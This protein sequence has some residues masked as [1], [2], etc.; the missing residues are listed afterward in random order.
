M[1]NKILVRLIVNSSPLLL[2]GL[3]PLELN[4]GL[5]APRY[6]KYGSINPYLIGIAVGCSLLLWADWAVRYEQMFRQK[7]TY[8]LLG[9]VLIFSILIRFCFFP[10]QS[11][12][13]CNALSA[14]YDFIQNNGGFLSLSKG[15]FS[16]YNV[17]YLYLLA[18]LT[19]T[20]LPSLYAIKLLSV[21]FDYGGAYGVY[22]IARLVFPDTSRRPFVAGVAVLFCPTVIFNSALWA[23]CDMMY[24]FFLLWATYFFM[25]NTP[26]QGV[27]MM[28]WFSCAFLFKLQAI[29]FVL[30]MLYAYILG[31]IRKRHIGILVG[32][33]F[34]TALPS[35]LLGR[36]FVDM[37]LVY[38]R[39]A[40]RQH[41]LSLN[42]ANI[43]QLFP[44]APVEPFKYAGI[45]AVGLAVLV[46]VF[47]F[48]KY[49]PALNA[50]QRLELALLSLGWI[51]YGL[52]QIHERYFFGVDVLA[53]LY[54]VIFPNRWHLSV[55]LIFVSL[56]SYQPYLFH[57]EPIPLWA[58]AL[59]YGYALIE[60]SR[61]W[62]D[63]VQ[64]SNRIA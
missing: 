49:R 14:W 51:P 16:D 21:G 58:L 28:F 45:L 22:K 18:L 40:A 23:Q 53:I 62:Y 42:A 31:D 52:P 33:W 39:Q 7:L 29:F 8:W 64:A 38:V 20:P 47:Y 50:V 56:M 10:F 26:M 5:I 61:Y 13:Y 2:L 12:D 41:P 44:S 9:I 60:L 15:N 17:V 4:L 19:Y 43:Y 55:I 54:M 1:K 30:P 3:L 59:L 32:L 48:L 63:R 35:W 57:S 36:S 37:A 25:K 24:V 27:Q 11:D 34:L 6:A 46:V